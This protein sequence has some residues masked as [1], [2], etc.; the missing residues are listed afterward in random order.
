[1]PNTYRIQVITKETVK[2]T[3]TEYQDAQYF[4]VPLDTKLSDFID[5]NEVGINAERDRRIANYVQAVLHPAPEKEPTKDELLLQKQQMEEAI[6]S[7]QSQLIEVN[8]KIDLMKLETPI[9]EEDVIEP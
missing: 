7:T 9:K 5:A 6:A 4:D 8:S 1:M 2:E 3:G